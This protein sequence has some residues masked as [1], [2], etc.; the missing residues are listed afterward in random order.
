MSDTDLIET[1]CRCGVTVM[2]S[3][4][5]TIEALCME[6]RYADTG[7]FPRFDPH[8]P[9]HPTVGYPAPGQGVRPLQPA[10]EAFPAPQL[11][12]RE[13]S[14]IGHDLAP[15]AHLAALAQEYGWGVKIQ[16]SRGNMPH[17][18]TGKPTALRNLIGVRFGG[19]VDTPRQ[20][21]AV[22]SKPVAGGTWTWSSVYIWGP[23]LPPYGGCGIT[24][25]RE[26]ITFARTEDYS[27][28]AWVA[29]IKAFR[30]VQ[31]EHRKIA[32]KIRAAKGNTRASEEA[33]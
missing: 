31:E 22:Y 21:Y 15:V 16:S 4:R 28:A 14:D 1:A 20:A 33:S 19:H 8:G 5:S 6:C 17:G 26:F 13:I 7:A 23:D 29:D 10:A 32:A 9:W 30:V 2:R 27:L 11:T 18:T 3:P 12:S 24:E 25:L